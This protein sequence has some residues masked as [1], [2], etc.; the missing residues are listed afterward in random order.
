MCLN[1][2]EGM[3]IAF[4]FDVSTA[5]DCAVVYSISFLKTAENRDKAYAYVKANKG[6]KTLDDTPCGKTL[7]EKGYQA[8]NEVA[9]DEIK[10]IWKVASERFIKSANGNLTAFADGAD[11]R[12]TFCT[13]EMPAILKNEKIKTINGIEK[14]EY[15]KKFRK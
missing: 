6:C 2:E 15:L 1:F 9:T 4:E 11:E 5:K 10:K 13:V 8:T 12:S 3:K 14:V 7:C